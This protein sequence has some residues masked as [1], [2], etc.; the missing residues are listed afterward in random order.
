MPEI[1]PVRAFVERIPEQPYFRQCLDDSDKTSSEILHRRTMLPRIA[2]YVQVLDRGRNFVG[3][4]VKKL[5]HDGAKEVLACLGG[6]VAEIEVV[7]KVWNASIVRVPIEMT[8]GGGALI[9][10]HQAQNLLS[11]AA[12]QRTLFPLPAIG[13]ESGSDMNDKLHRLTYTLYP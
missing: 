8:D 4:E 13:V 11:F 5:G 1:V 7:I 9:I 10:A 6:L 12:H 3:K 2:T